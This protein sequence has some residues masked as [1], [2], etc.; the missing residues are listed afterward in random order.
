MPFFPQPI[1]CSPNPKFITKYLY[2]QLAMVDCQSV[3]SRVTPPFRRPI[4]LLAR[5]LF[6]IR[7]LTGLSLLQ[8]VDRAADTLTTSVQNVGIDHR[9]AHILVT[10]QFL[11]SSNVVSV[12]Q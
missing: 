10:K 1:T 8:L 11:D 9:R 3:S 5:G 7:L 12:L 6:Q 2:F 4:A